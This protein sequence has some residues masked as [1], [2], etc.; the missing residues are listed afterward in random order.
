MKLER[1]K[2]WWLAQARREG[3]APVGAGIMAFDPKPEQEAAPRPVE[4]LE[5][6]RI[7]FGRL[8]NLS[9]RRR[10][11]T[12]ER[13]AEIASL[14]P[15]ELLKIEDDVRYVPEPRTVYQLA[16]TFEFSHQ[17]MLQLAGLAAANDDGFR[18]EAVR[19]AARS[20]SFEKLTPEETSALEAFVQILSEQDSKR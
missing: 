15:S 13:L 9:R 14:D 8:I 17:Y 20:E 10:G 16:K 12:L 7:A 11:Y 1:S 4:A 6:V 3:D 18:H 19:F 5:E 2:E